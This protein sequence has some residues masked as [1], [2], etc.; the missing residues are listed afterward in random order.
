MA[1]CSECTY[2]KPNDPDLYG[3][4]WCEKKLERVSAYQEECSRFCR[5]YSRS[6]NASKSYEDFS[7]NNSGS[8]GCY[9]TTMLCEILKLSDN[10]PFLN[11]IR[12]FRNDVLQKDEKYKQI[13]VEYDLVGPMIANN[14]N[15]DPLRYQIAA[16][17]FFKY[18]KPITK[19]I[20]ENKNQEAII[21]YTEMTNNL[22]SF[23]NINKTI[24]V[25]YINN[26]DIKESGHGVY[27]VKKITY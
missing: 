18:I 11:T 5:A 9:L 20:K 1:K 6:S 13:L 27:R 21:S 22:K 7:N 14:L 10:N 24:N 2:L 8:P 15:N 12:N 19:L 25:N 4:Y 23:Y 3:K 17:M 26:A 16:N